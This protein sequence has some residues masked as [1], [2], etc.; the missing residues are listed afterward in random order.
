MLTVETDNSLKQRLLRFY[1][2]K[3]HII[4]SSLLLEYVFLKKERIELLSH[5]KWWSLS[6][7]LVSVFFG[8]WFLL[9]PVTS[10]LSFAHA[11]TFPAQRCNSLRRWVFS[12]NSPFSWNAFACRDKNNDFP[13]FEGTQSLRNPPCC[14][15]SNEEWPNRA[16]NG[17][18]LRY[19]A[20]VEL[21]SS[22]LQSQ[23]S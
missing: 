1:Q 9:V 11:C 22:K 19:P 16:I 13:R 18:F 23:N 21:T 12:L 8:E 6:N 5:E 20:S 15:F 4:Q 2:P 10:E 3:S 14:L 17:F 7:N